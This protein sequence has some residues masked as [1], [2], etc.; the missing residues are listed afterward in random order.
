M[1]NLAGATAEPLTFD[2]PGLTPTPQSLAL[3]F[4][5]TDPANLATAISLQ[6]V[7]GSD[8]VRWQIPPEQV[9]TI[10]DQVATYL[11]SIQNTLP[12]LL[13]DPTQ[14]Y[15]FAL[16]L[17][18]DGV[19]DPAP[20][21]TLQLQQRT[22]QGIPT[23]ADDT[24]R[25][26]LFDE[27]SGLA[28]LW[29]SPNSAR[30]NEDRVPVNNEDVVLANG[31]RVLILAEQEGFYRVQIVSATDSASNPTD[32]TTARQGWISTQYI[33]GTGQPTPTTDRDN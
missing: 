13:T 12:G 25:A 17:Q 32:I 2:I 33:A 3:A 14:P 23:Q 8:P 6:P 28:L 19:P 27:T 21:L 1:L 16:T 4:P 24:N 9:V 5:T 31:D 22:V 11:A 29:Q 26:D 20:A 10:P 18:K 15:S 30:T 7:T